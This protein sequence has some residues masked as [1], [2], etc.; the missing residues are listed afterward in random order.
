MLSSIEAEADYYAAVDDLI[1]AHA[2]AFYLK[3]AASAQ[4]KAALLT[5]VRISW[6]DTVDSVSAFKMDAHLEELFMTEMACSKH[7]LSKI[8]CSA[9]ITMSL[10]LAYQLTK[11]AH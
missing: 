9:S 8:D 1:K 10:K 5:Q 2:T 7:I 3:T 4:I 11:L 6:S